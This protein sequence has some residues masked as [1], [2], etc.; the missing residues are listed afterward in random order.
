M[1]HLVLYQPEIPHNTG[2][3]GRLCVATG[4]RLHLIR[5]LG[6]SLAD[7]HLK[8]AG[9]DYWAEVDLRIWESWE[10]FLQSSGADKESLW[11]LS[12]KGS[13]Q[14]WDAD[15]AG[16]EVWLVLGPETRGLPEALLAGFPNRVLRLPMQG[17]RSLNLA[18]AAAAALYEALRQRAIPGG[19][20]K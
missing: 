20:G 18:T 11:F 14:H 2:A 10:A 3:C 16:E 12:T 8:R 9:L 5:P 6:F 15:L 4:S 13:T 7:K 19:A 1:L 17:V